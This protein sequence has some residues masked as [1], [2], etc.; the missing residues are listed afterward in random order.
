MKNKYEDYCYICGEVVMEGAGVAE[1][2]PRKSG[3]AGFGSTKWIVR[4]TACTAG[5]PVQDDVTK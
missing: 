5:V 3:E 1:Q 2:V 4:H